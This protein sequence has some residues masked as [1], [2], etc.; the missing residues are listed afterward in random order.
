MDKSVQRYNTDKAVAQYYRMQYAPYLD[1]QPP[2]ITENFYSQIQAVLSSLPELKHVCEIGCGLGRVLFDMANKRPEIDALLGTDI[3]ETFVAECQKIRDGRSVVSPKFAVSQ[4]ERLN[5]TVMDAQH[6]SLQDGT[7][8]LVVCLNVI[9]R[10]PEPKQ[11]LSE[12]S[13]IVRQTGY[14]LIADPY[15]WNE[16][17]TAKEKHIASINDVYTQNQ[18]EFIIDRDIDFDIFIHTRKMIKYR[19]H[20]L[21]LKKK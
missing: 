20:L 1:E 13:R 19:N 12:L 16:Q 8:D 11:V 17:Y 4:P 21:L 10:V 7:F 3:S 6:M 15:D 14:L 9:D 18:W 5:F 2:A